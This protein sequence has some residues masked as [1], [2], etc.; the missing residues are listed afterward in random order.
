MQLVANIMYEAP[1]DFVFAHAPFV[2]RLLER[3]KR[4]DAESVKR[5][6]SNS[7]NGRI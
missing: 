4:V 2:E 1:P 5:S 3:A 6:L 7:A